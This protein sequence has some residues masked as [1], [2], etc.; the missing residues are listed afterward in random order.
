MIFVGSQESLNIQ[1]EREVGDCFQ[2]CIFSSPELSRLL[3]CVQFLFLLFSPSLPFVKTKY[4]EVWATVVK[5]FCLWYGLR[6]TLTF[7]MK[8][9]G[10]VEGRVLLVH[11]QIWWSYTTGPV[12]ILS[13]AVNRC[14][15]SQSNLLLV[16]NRCRL[17]KDNFFFG[18][19]YYRQLRI[20]NTELS[21]C[22]GLHRHNHSH[23]Y[24]YT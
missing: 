15:R 4:L 24:W 1:Q 3:W 7:L 16:M 22:Y 10:L 9:I 23:S 6:E 19:C 13:P 5:M 21:H 17:N 12:G 14:M 20:I 11:W 8:I 2:N 18:T